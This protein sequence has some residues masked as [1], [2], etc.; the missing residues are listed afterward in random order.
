MKQ[1]ILN[2]LYRSFEENLS[3][4][5]KETLDKELEHSQTL[6]NERDK[7][8]KMRGLVKTDPNY[9]F[10]PLFADRVMGKI[11]TQVKTNSPTVQEFFDSLLWTFRRVAIAGVFAVLLLFTYNIINSGQFSLTSMLGMPQLTVEDTLE[12][13]D[14]TE[15]EIL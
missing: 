12:L 11:Q 2:L 6:R 9:T 13:D 14:F 5:E 3:Q 8:I 15:R 4:T 7:I 10:Q 1:K